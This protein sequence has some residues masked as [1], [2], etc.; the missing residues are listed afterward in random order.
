MSLTSTQ[1]PPPTPK[2]SSPSNGGT[3]PALLVFMAGLILVA[4]LWSFHAPRNH[5]RW[6]PNGGLR[7]GRFGSAVTAGAFPKNGAQA[8]GAIEV[9]LEPS[10]DDDKTTILAFDGGDEH[11]V[12]FLLQQYDHHLIL[13]HDVNNRLGIRST[14]TLIVS[15][16]FNRKQPVFL[17]I[18]LAERRGAVYVNGKLARDGESLPIPADSFTGRLV[19]ANSP[20]SDNSWAGRIGRL[21]IYRSELSPADVKQHYNDF[22]Q[23]RR[24]PNADQI[25]DYDF[26]EGSGS[27][28]H[29][30]RDS[31]TDLVIPAKYFVLHPEWL[32]SPW[33][34][35]DDEWSRW[36]DIIINITG[37]IPFGF[38][39]VAF[40]TR[41][42]K[43]RRPVLITLLIGFLLSFCIESL[44]YYLPTRDSDATDV[45][46]NTLGTALGI[47][48][49][50][51]SL[52]DILWD[53][54]ENFVDSLLRPK[55]VWN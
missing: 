50:R 41:T 10:F 47:V 22:V 4:G 9:V 30:L 5:V 37:F 23:R 42:G 45:M 8:S 12:P 17:T 52:R 51:S 13:R 28:A 36:K 26:H 2:A 44:Q 34:E 40:L 46:T 33:R 49:W 31:S 38:S 43:T 3:I 16:V 6:D 54:I 24:I 53:P 35:Y 20:I 29:N 14:T 25:A 7:F 27:V 18:T 15:D 19:L 1:V 21:A 48:L 39:L 11:R 32:L 55:K